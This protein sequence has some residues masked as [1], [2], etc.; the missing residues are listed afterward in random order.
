MSTIRIAFNRPSVVGDELTSMSEAIRSGRLCGS[1][2]C[3]EKCQRLL[4]EQLQVKKALLTT[5]CTDALE[6]C[7]LL[8][9]LQ[10]G[11][12]VIAPSFTFVSTVN[13]FVLR[14]AR[15]V[16]VDIRPDTLNV[17]E[18]L[19]EERI[20]R[21]TRAIVVVHYAG[22]GCE[23][24][25]IL[26]I[27][28]RHGIPVVE[29][30]AHGLYGKYRGKFLGSFGQLATQSFHDTK[31]LTC[32]EGGALLINAPR[33][34]ARAEIVREVGTDR[35]R[36]LRGEVDKYGWVD[37]GSSYRLSDLLAAFLHVQLQACCRIQN[38]R[39]QI[40]D[41]YYAG[42][43]GWARMHGVQLPTVPAHCEQA[44]HMFYL[45][46]PSC[47]AR[48]GLIAHLKQRGIASVFHY[49][50]L[51]LSSMGLRFGGRAGDLPVTEDVSEHLLRLPFFNALTDVEQ[52]RVIAAVQDYDA[53]SAPCDR[54]GPRLGD[55]HS[56][57]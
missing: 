46:M 14:G 7:G 6:M 26:K 10:P 30:N 12:E 42:L 37:V 27:A 28:A 55:F 34:I 11:D 25:A 3:S 18:T 17:D 53:S 36:M 39:K 16:F 15:P 56:A 41:A 57:A 52:S 4:E 31:N 44:Y 20:T 38:K 9:D 29:D 43:A 33:Y 47:D 45:L 19:L 49:A 48:Q 32:G 2:P 23:M 1:G 24:D 54:K 40:W 51:H 8:L 35:S 5:S 22:V 50:P 21:R 13:A